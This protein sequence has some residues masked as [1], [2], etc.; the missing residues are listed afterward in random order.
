MIAPAVI[1]AALAFWAP[2]N[3]GKVPC[4]GHLTINR[5]AYGEVPA[6]L[7]VDT[8]A[9]A[10][11]GEGCGSV[12]L[13]DGIEY[14]PTPAYLCDVIAHE[15]GHAVFGLR[16]TSGR[17]DVMDADAPA[18]NAVCDQLAWWKPVRLRSRAARSRKRV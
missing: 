13:R 15:V 2:Y 4:D 1:A 17:H 18:G 10:R 7:P 16:H 12:Y 5:Y 8:P 6:E 14:G 3:D 11:I 9:Y